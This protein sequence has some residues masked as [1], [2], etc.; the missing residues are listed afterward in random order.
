M[1]N[2]KTGNSAFLLFLPHSIDPFIPLQ[3]LTIKYFQLS[4]RFEIDNVTIAFISTNV[5]YDKVKEYEI[6]CLSLTLVVAEFGKELNLKIEDVFMIKR[7][8]V[9]Y[10]SFD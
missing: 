10:V 8:K 5:T 6:L 3:P 1:S 2:R 4:F 9:V 7:F